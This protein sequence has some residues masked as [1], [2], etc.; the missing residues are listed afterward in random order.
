MA[1]T[2]LLHGKPTE[3]RPAIARYESQGSFGSVEISWGIIFYTR[4]VLLTSHY[5]KRLFEH[6]S[7]PRVAGSDIRLLSYLWS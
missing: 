7:Q 3:E 5:E 1:G 4:K 6:A 2:T